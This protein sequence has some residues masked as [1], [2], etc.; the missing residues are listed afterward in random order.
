MLGSVAGL[1][2]TYYGY[3]V[4]SIPAVDSILVATFAPLIFAN[5]D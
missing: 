5:T 2:G 3:S 4:T 1:A